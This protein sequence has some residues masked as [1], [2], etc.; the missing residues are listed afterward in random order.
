M[1]MTPGGADGTVE[2][3]DLAMVPDFPDGHAAGIPHSAP[4]DT[5]NAGKHH[6]GTDLLDCAELSDRISKQGVE[7]T[8]KVY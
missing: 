8:D 6:T 5:P 4:G 7:K 1:D 3:D 2:T